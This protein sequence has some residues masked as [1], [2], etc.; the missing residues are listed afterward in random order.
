MGHWGIAGGTKIAAAA[1]GVVV[2]VA[3]ILIGWLVFRD[4]DDGGLA[5]PIELPEGTPRPTFGT[6]PPVRAVEELIDTATGR[7]PP[8]VWSALGAK[9]RTDGTVPVIVELRARLI[10]RVLRSLAGTRY[11]NLKQFETIPAFSLHASERT[12]RILR[13][14]PLV[15]SISEDRPVP[16]PEP[17]PGAEVLPPGVAEKLKEGW[18]ITVAGMREAWDNGYDGRGQ[19]VA[20][21][22]SGVDANHDW[23]NGRVVAEACYSTLGLCP[24]G[25][26]RAEGPGMGQPCPQAI[27]GCAHGTHTGHT[28]AGLYGVARAAGIIAVQVF[29][30]FT[31]NDCTAN[32]LPSPCA[33]SYPSDQMEGLEFVLKRKRAGSAVASVNISIGGGKYRRHCDR[34]NPPFTRLVTRLRRAGVV[35][36]VSSGNDGAGNAIGS[37]ACISKAVSVGA[38]TLIRQRD[39]VAEAFSNSAKILNWLAPGD[40]IYSAVPGNGAESWDGTSMAVPHAA[41]AFAV[42][43]QLQPGGNA[44]PLLQ[45]LAASGPK[46]RDTRN[47]LRKPRINVWQAWIKLY[48]ANR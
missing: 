34:R 38:T 47:G 25:H 22:D 9:A 17:R 2:V 3:A 48:N 7:T 12:L 45:A 21:L 30:K 29:S 14:L 31:G 36:F 8:G 43:R 1:L 6:L 24:G 20:I 27:S 33:L 28:A 40:D 44:R 4:G 18:D 16:L 10:R 46:I 23:L 19:E 13:R 39:A 37:P 5:A 35:T 11:T 26:K 15:A 32:D 42:L 41:G